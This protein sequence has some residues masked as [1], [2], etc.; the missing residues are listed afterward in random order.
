MF[1]LYTVTVHALVPLTGDAAFL[2]KPIKAGFEKAV[3][4]INKFCSSDSTSCTLPIIKYFDTKSSPAT[5]LQIFKMSYNSGVKMFVGLVTSSEAKEVAEYASQHATDAIIISPSSTAT[6]LCKYKNQLYRLTM[7]DRGYAEVLFDI[8]MKRQQNLNGDT[9]AVQVVSRDD[10]HG[11]GLFNDISNKLKDSFKVLP[12]IKYDH[13]GLTAS[14]A[15]YIAS[16]VNSSIG[17]EKYAVIVLTGLTEVEL[18]LEG[19]DQYKNLKD[20]ARYT[21]MLSDALTLS[22]VKIPATLDVFGLTFAGTVPN[23]KKIHRE[24]NGVKLYLQERGLPVMIQSLIAYDIISFIHKAYK[25]YKSTTVTEGLTG[26]IDFNSCHE[27]SYG[28]YLLVANPNINNVDN[29]VVKVEMKKWIDMSHYAVNS[30]EEKMSQQELLSVIREDGLSLLAIMEINVGSTLKID[31]SSTLSPAAVFQK[32]DLL[33]T[34]VKIGDENCERTAHVSIQSTDDITEE[35][36]HTNYTVKTFPEK[37]AF[38]VQHGFIM[39]GTCQTSNTTLHFT[40]VCP[41]SMV[42]GTELACTTKVERKNELSTQSGTIQKVSA[43]LTLVCVIGAFIC[44]LGTVATLGA[45]A[46]ACGVFAAG[47]G[48]LGGTTAVAAAF[49]YV[50]TELFVQGHLPPQLMLADIS[51]AH[52][53]AIEY[54]LTR[55]GY[56][57]IGSAI[58]S[59]MRSSE[60]FTDMVKYFAIPWAEEMAY[61]EGYRQV[62]NELGAWVMSVGSVICAIVG[63]IQTIGIY[64]IMGMLYNMVI[65]ILIIVCRWSGSCDDC[66]NV[67]EKKPATSQS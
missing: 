52:R 33:E 30:L 45:I 50:C 53:F 2:G 25:N 55:Q 61:N 13:Q 37:L 36:L 18:I 63:V 38:P 5:A 44:V 4:D 7:D 35:P 17:G 65:Y 14:H 21:V 15:Q 34:L 54:P 39:E 56:N 64:N 8:L 49:T 6:E 58:A 28:S 29:L 26:A 1:F 19:I 43:A 32:I 11:N 40:K 10:I 22:N 16:Q 42:A 51:F 24:R 62:G 57:V 66:C 31:V 60:T 27:R 20:S 3:H 9:I 47:C 48:I 12:H 59:M 67:A 46:P 41:G 23:S